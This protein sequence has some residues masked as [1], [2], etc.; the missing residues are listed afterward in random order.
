MNKWIEDTWQFFHANP[1]L[2]YEEFVTTAKIKELLEEF[3]M[4]RPLESEV[5]PFSLSV[6]API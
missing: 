1:E 6:Q 5:I 3:G 4:E 2:G